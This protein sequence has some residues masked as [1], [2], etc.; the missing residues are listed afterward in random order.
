MKDYQRVRLHQAGIAVE[1]FYRDSFAGDNPQVK[2]FPSVWMKIFIKT[3]TNSTRRRVLIIPN[4]LCSNSQPLRSSQILNADFGNAPFRGLVHIDIT[5]E[6]LRPALVF[7]LYMSHKS[8]F[9]IE[10]ATAV[11][12]FLSRV[13]P[14][15]N[16]VRL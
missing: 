14:E 6:P 16:R 5:H 9:G 7:N 2:I 3:L 15:G 4:P 1:S 11:A 13:D 8:H 10:L 12:L